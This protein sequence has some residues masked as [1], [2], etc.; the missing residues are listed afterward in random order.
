M[1]ALV[2]ENG[3]GKTTLMRIAFG[4]ISAD[5][6]TITVAGTGRQI[7][8]AADAIDAGIG[9]VH[10]HFTNVPAMT[11]AENVAL[12]GRGRLSMTDASRR[13]ND[14][15]ARSGLVLDP[16]A[17]AAELPVGGQQRLEIVKA[18][19]RNTQTLILDEPTAVLAPAEADELLRW[20]RRFA[21]GGNAVVL[22][23]HK[24]DEALS[25]ADDVTVLRRGRVA[26]HAAAST[27]TAD[28]LANAMLGEDLS[29][30]GKR[31]NGS[32]GWSRRCIRRGR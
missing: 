28:G 14:I 31:S 3:A 2:G 20:L 13:V 29:P 1:H 10:Q 27:V 30:T 21:D 23:T 5:T 19:A 9:M 11:V 26:L 7:T 16:V 15:G 32:T 22:I 18:L 6:G 24:L 17:R 25:I 4:L 8:S 12:G